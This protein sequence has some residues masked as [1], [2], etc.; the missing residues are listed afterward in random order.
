ME[1]KYGKGKTSKLVN[2]LVR[3]KLEYIH[4]KVLLPRS[5]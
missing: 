2:K 4:K 5:E 1:K 3:E